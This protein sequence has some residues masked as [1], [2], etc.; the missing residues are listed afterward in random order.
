MPESVEIFDK[1]I[2]DSAEETGGTVK[3][4]PSRSKDYPAGRVKERE[5]VSVIQITQR[6]M[7]L[8]PLLTDRHTVRGFMGA[9]IRKRRIE[10]EMTQE[11]L[12]QLMDISRETISQYEIGKSRLDAADLPRLCTTLDVPLAYFYQDIYK[13]AAL[14]RMAANASPENTHEM[15]VLYDRLDEPAQRVL[16]D[17][18]MSLYQNRPP[19]AGGGESEEE[20]PVAK[21]SEAVL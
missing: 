14:E 3:H 13:N 12:G 4:H 17:V 1:G 2:A 20:D 6:I 7:N 5:H 9:R 11:N 8:A 19:S 10:L 15:L 18:A 16:V 21:Y